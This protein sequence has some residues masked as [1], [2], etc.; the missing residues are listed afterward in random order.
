MRQKLTNA[1][2]IIVGCV[3]YAFAFNLFFD[4]FRISPGGVSGLSMILSYFTG[5][6]VGTG[7]ILMNIP[8]VIMAYMRLGKIFIL[9]TA[10]ATA[11]SSVLI[12]LTAWVSPP[13]DDLLLASLCGGVLIGVGLGL[14]FRGGAT[15]GGSD[16]ASK[17]LLS[18]RPHL[19]MGKIVLGID[20]FII[21]LTA[22]VFRDFSLA[23]Y[24]FIAL[25]IAAKILDSVLYGLD[26]ATVTYII[27]EQHQEIGAAIQTRLGRG[28]TYLE[29]EGG[30]KGGS[31]RVVLCAIKRGQLT[32]LRGV[33]GDLD[34]HAFLIVTEGHQIFGDG[35][36]SGEE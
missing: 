36:L 6:S 4:P 2:L 21:G 15:T 33:V 8:L 3:L 22:F 10:V 24:A 31:K 30:Y 14:V 19:R 32:A 25:Y 9:S 13:V 23:V 29:A 28:V 12:D 7:I 17:L 34:P 27:S 16:I 26:F 1:A 11:L 35:F 20:G 5:L 18:V